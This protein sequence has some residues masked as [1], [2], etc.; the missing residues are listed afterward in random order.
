MMTYVSYIV[1]FLGVIY[2]GYT[3]GLV[4]SA[5]VANKEMKKKDEL[6]ELYQTMIANMTQMINSYIEEKKDANKGKE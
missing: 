1:I 2:L 4:H 6:V 3:I 5:V